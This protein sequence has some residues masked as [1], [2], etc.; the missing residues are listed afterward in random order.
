MGDAGNWNG[1]RDS[2]TGLQQPPPCPIAIVGIGLRL[3][4]GVNSASSL[5][6]FLISKRSGRCLVPAGRYNVDAFYK[7][8]K[9]TGSVASRYGYFI[10]DDIEHFDAS[11]FSMSKSE[12][13]RLDPQQRLLLEV[14]WECM[15]SGGQKDWRGQNIGCY[16]GVFGDVSSEKSQS[17]P[18]KLIVIGLARYG[19]K[20]CS[21]CRTLSSCRLRIPRH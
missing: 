15:E 8:S 7:P 10:Q 20:R 18:V 16:V 4:G 21:E 19:C 14:V 6:E 9:T 1:P 12:V 13:Q 5:W 17:A 3:P 2:T 11:F